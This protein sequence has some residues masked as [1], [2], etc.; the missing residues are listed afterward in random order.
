MLVLEVLVDYLFYAINVQMV[1]NGASLRWHGLQSGT[2]RWLKYIFM[3]FIRVSFF[4]SSYNAA[5]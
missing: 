3:M 4:K 1:V 5:N 2:L